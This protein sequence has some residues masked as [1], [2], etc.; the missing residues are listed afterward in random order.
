MERDLQNGETHY[1]VF[2]DSGE[3]EMPGHELCTRH[4]HQE[5]WSISTDDP[6][7]YR[8]TS[9]YICWMRRGDWSI[10]TESESS[11]SCDAEN[12]YIKASVTAYE[13]EQQIN[14]RMWEKTIK[15]DFI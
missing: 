15:R 3:S 9:L 14:Q 12:F 2:D 13:S 11:F 5:C 1:H 10:R 8:A 4:T 7:S 6:L